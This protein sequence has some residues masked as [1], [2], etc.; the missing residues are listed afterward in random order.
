MKHSLIANVDI[1]ALTS[2]IVT[3]N[4]TLHIN[5]VLKFMNF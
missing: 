2:Q 1:V 5:F 4:Y 3:L